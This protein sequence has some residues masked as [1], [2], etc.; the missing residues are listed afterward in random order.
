M[1]NAG[2][3]CPLHPA[4]GHLVAHNNAIIKYMGVWIMDNNGLN[5]CCHDNGITF[6]TL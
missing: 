1:E 3:G 2:Q 6:F 5:T 4:D